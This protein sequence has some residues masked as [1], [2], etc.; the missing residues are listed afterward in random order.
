MTLLVVNCGSSSL[1]CRVF[2]AEDRSVAEG[3]VTRIGDAHSALEW[4]Q[5]GGAERRELDRVDHAGAFE[6]LC[7]LLYGG[8]AQP[9]PTIVGHRVVH[10]GEDFREATPIDDEV[11]H[12]IDALAPLAPLHNPLCLTG[13]RAARARFPD[14]QHVAVFDTAFHATLPPR[15]YLYALPLALYEEAGVRRYGFHG[16]SHAHASERVA[17]LLGETPRRLVS[18]H[19]GAGCSLAAIEDGSA[20]DTTMGLTPLEGLVMAT[21]SGD[22]DP[23]L[24]AYLA[25]RR[26]M[27]LE[28][29]DRLL[30]HESGL[31]GLSGRTGDIREL[32]ALAADGDALAEQALDVFAYRA[33]KA[34]GAAIAALGGCDALVF[35]GGAGA[36]SHALRERILS[37]LSGLGIRLGAARNVAADG[38][39][40]V[41]SEAGAPVS[42]LVVPANEELHIAR[43]AR[44][45]LD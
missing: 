10:G 21:R 26:G 41:I 1:K 15:A 39:E 33:R 11:E 32:Q 8:D 28:A 43:E 30:N 34:I 9:A 31:L 22:V 42:I 44:A 12:A 38:Q 3:S 40:A 14:A 6:A 35:T 5:A 27:S 19:L 23:G 7:E 45:A 36:N 37:P 29:I 2:D 20:I 18:C 16:T 24:F 17:A 4:A 25:E 13:I